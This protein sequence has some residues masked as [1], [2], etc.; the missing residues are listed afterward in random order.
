VNLKQIINLLLIKLNTLY[1]KGKR[2]RQEE[3]KVKVKL[4]FTLVQVLRLC[5]GHTAQMGSRSIALL[6]FDH[7][8]RRGEGSESRPGRSLPQG[9]TRYPV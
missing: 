6:F 4:K 2:V 7:G 3:V 8:I 5:T 1:I 9:K